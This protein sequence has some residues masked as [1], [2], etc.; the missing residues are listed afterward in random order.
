MAWTAAQEKAITSEARELLVSA[1]AGSGKTTVLV[2]RVCRLIENNS[3]IGIGNIL[4][5]TFTKSA[6]AEMKARINASLQKRGAESERMRRE[7]ALTECA[8]ISTIHSFCGEIIRSFFPLLGVDPMYRI[9][10]DSEGAA[11]SDKALED[12]L[13][14]GYDDA[15][16]DFRALTK[17]F[18]D[19]EIMESVRSLHSFLSARADAEEFTE[20]ALSSF[21]QTADELLASKWFSYMLELTTKKLSAFAY[22]AESFRALCASSEVPEA[23]EETAKRDIADIKALAAELQKGGRDAAFA[24][25]AFTLSTLGRAKKSDMA[26]K[27]AQE[28]CK[29]ARDTYK[30]GLAKLLEPFCFTY[31]EEELRQ[32]SI[33]APLRAVCALERR[34]TALFTEAKSLAGGLDF[35]DLEHFA[36]QALQDAEVRSALSEK[37][38]AVF[39]D[40]YQDV[41][42]LQEAILSSLRGL[43]S[44]FMVGDVKQSIYRF[45]QADPTLFINKYEAFSPSDEGGERR[46]DLSSNFRSRG[47]ILRAVN[48]VF[49]SSMN[50]DTAEI[51]YD[52]AAKLIPGLES[53]DDP[54][55]TLMLFSRE[56]QLDEDEERRGA[57]YSEAS[58]TGREIQRLIGKPFTDKGEERTINYSDIVILL[59]SRTD[60]TELLS[61][62]LTAMGIPNVTDVGAS[63][64]QMPEIAQLLSTLAYLDNPLQDIPLL[65]ALRLPVFSLSEEELAAFRIEGGGESFC[66]SFESCLSQNGKTGDRARECEKTL[67]R[68]RQLARYMA[69]DKLSETIMEESGLYSFAASLPDGDLRQANLRLLSEKARRFIETRFGGLSEFLSF[70]SDVKLKDSEVAQ[71]FSENENAVRIMTIHKSK[72]L[73]FPVVFILQLGKK[74]SQAKDSSPL[75]LSR[76][77]GLSLPAAFPD[78]NLKQRSFVEKAIKA[79]READERSEA[80]RL[81]YVAMTRPRYALYLVGTLHPSRSLPVWNMPAGRLRS[82]SA[83]SALDWIMQPL[84]KPTNADERGIDTESVMLSTT[85]EGLSTTFPLSAT[86]WNIRVF[87][88]SQH[89]AADKS[90]VIHNRIERL[91]SAVSVKPSEETIV[92]LSRKPETEKLLSRRK[93]TVTELARG[94]IPGDNADE[95]NGENK[96]ALWDKEMP[97]MPPFMEEEKPDGAS[98]GSAYHLLLSRLPLDS[99]RS[100][101]T[102]ERRGIVGATLKRLAERRAIPESIADRI[103]PAYVLR[104]VESDLGR[105]MLSAKTVHREWSFV[106]ELRGGSLVLQGVVDL[107]IEAPEGLIL[108]DYKTD[109]PDDRAAL[110]E[111]YSPQVNMYRQAVE[112][113]TGKK[114]IKACLFLI[115]SG[116]TLDIAENKEDKAE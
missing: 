81:L 70:T 9:L 47:N 102:A 59:R 25:R 29:E 71:L 14:E 113:I 58:E 75:A 18:T 41:S 34:Y 44:Y 7:A 40:E 36:Y 101:D 13:T 1:A 38:K 42:N 57:L 109:R 69:V 110:L 76:L 20:A 51:E 52:E 35:N 66:E 61:E 5:V 104:F 103:N 97:E 49:E 106:R 90:E 54:P 111:R 30:K 37:Y 3:E 74:L 46:I 19:A 26:D 83:Q 23:Y 55:V 87:G 24:A 11:M 95:E 21:P 96:E 60:V 99:L 93:T 32:Q 16:E 92:R 107:C 105:E 50:R 115:R 80:L 4:L 85:R 43:S 45:R 65:A 67:A 114:V 89:T 108:V 91:S 100:A 86:R 112:A 73:E 62:T 48:Q 22:M 77:G 63:Y 116:E 27:E 31:E 10:P 79:Q 82:L 33:I 39:I 64:Y 98:L 84:S 94:E 28:R 72:G 56:E 8:S 78:K 2:E 6:A 17:R 15:D 12:A 88:F 68:W 53:E